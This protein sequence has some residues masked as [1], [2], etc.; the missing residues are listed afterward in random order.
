MKQLF[1]NGKAVGSI[2]KT[3]TP[4]TKPETN[5]KPTSKPK[6]DSDR[7]AAPFIPDS[8]SDPTASAALRNLMREEER[9]EQEKRK[10][11]RPKKRRKKKRMQDK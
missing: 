10:A 4:D 1:I 5:A 3:K 2:W 8:Y 7:K 11:Q 9:L 6:H